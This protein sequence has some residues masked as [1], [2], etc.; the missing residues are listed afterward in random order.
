MFVRSNPGIA[1]R[2][3]Y[4]KPMYIPGYFR[5]ED[6]NLVRELM[7]RNPFATIVT[8]GPDGPFATHIPVL[9]EDGENLLIAAHVARANPHWKLFEGPLPTLAIFH[10]PHA[11]VSPRLYVVDGSVPT[12]NY[13]SVHCYGQPVLIEDQDEALLHVQTVVHTFDAGLELAR[14]ASMDETMLRRMLG[15]IVAFRMPVDRFEAKIKLNQNKTAADREAV[16]A[17]MLASPDPIEREVGR[18][19]AQSQR[20]G[21]R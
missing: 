15:G 7:R 5:L 16:M 11:Y 17:A 3:E 21:L 13:A 8:S 12:W 18:L 4:N 2:P 10:G 19:M 1:P 20:S 6:P 14:P 9:V